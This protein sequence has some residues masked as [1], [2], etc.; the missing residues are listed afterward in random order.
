MG[1]DKKLLL[2]HTSMERVS[3]DE[4]VNVLLTPQFYTLKKEALPVKYAYQAKKIA[5]SLFD[6]LLEE[7]GNY[8]YLV[9]KEEETWVF[10][11]YDLGSITAFLESKGI[12]A[13]KVSKVFFAQQAVDSFTAPLALNEKEA[14]VVLDNTVVLVPRMALGSEEEP[15]LKVDSS[16]TPKGGISLQGSSTSFITQKQALLLAAL[17]MLFAG[18][19]FFEGSR[20][21][22]ENESAKDEL[23]SLYAS[24]PAL[25]SSYAREGIVNKYRTI[26]VKERKKRDAIK[27]FSGMIFKGVTL[28]SLNVTTKGFKAQ[29]ACTNTEV[30]KRLKELAK[31]AHYNIAKVKGSTDLSIEGTL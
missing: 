15:S 11:A 17:F 30:A 4:S 6:G 21:G 1:K 19:F 12:T 18:I 20:Y 26:D 22:G 27:T 7:G 24:Y 5:P 14:L 9:M 23:Q 16:F 25:E 29:F 8:N 3:L 28:T 10:I 2:V 13:D 31:K